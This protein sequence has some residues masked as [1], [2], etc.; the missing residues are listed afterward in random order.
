MRS[1]SFRGYNV[2]KAILFGVTYGRVKFRYF[3]RF[4]NK[5]GSAQWLTKSSNVNAGGYCHRTP[6]STGGTARTVWFSDEFTPRYDWTWN[7]FFVSASLRFYC[8]QR[9]ACSLAPTRE[10]TTSTPSTTK[11]W[12]FVRRHE[13]SH[14]QDGSYTVEGAGSRSSE[15]Q[16]LPPQNSLGTSAGTCGADGRQFCNA[17]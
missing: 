10:N 1:T 2:S 3:Q 17:R 11:L 16:V 7:N 9:C 14:N 15:L 12:A 5:C 8:W 6:L 4:L 13:I